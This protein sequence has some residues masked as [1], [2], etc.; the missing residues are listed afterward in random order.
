MLGVGYNKGKK[1]EPALDQMPVWSLREGTVVPITGSKASA[2]LG[3][4]WLLLVCGRR[5]MFPEV[6]RALGPLH[7]VSFMLRQP[8]HTLEKNFQTWSTAER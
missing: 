8:E 7:I 5:L 1:R 6:L 2:A 3:L 4:I